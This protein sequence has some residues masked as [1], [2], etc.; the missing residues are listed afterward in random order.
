MEKESESSLAPTSDPVAVQESSGFM[1]PAE[2]TEKVT[3]GEAIVVDVREP[4][5][6]EEGVVEFAYLLPLSDLRGDRELWVGFLQEHRD[7][8]IILYC[9]SG[10]RSG[11]AAEILAKEGFEV[12]NAGG[13][14][15]WQAAGSPERGPEDARRGHR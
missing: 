9:R 2:A 14:R 4:D 12:A 8:E 11:V 15:D 7:Q 6:W 1:T 5:E 10:N 3:S 13:F